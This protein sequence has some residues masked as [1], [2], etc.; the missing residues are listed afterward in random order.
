MVL[1]VEM[2]L[3][4]HHRGEFNSCPLVTKMNSLGFHGVLI[5]EFETPKRKWILL[6]TSEYVEDIYTKF[7]ILKYIIILIYELSTRQQQIGKKYYLQLFLKPVS[8]HIY[9][10]YIYMCIF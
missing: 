3:K 10:Q 9:M 6:F 8:L 5:I 7:Y 2:N 4:V 1:R